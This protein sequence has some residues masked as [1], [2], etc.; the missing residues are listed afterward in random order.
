MS[1]FNEGD[2]IEGKYKVIK[3]IGEGGM[4]RV[5]L[6]ED[7]QKA[8]KWALKVNRDPEEVDAT[9][10]EAY[11]QFLKEVSALST[12]KHP[13]I[14]SI[15]D[16]FSNGTQH[17]VVEEFIEGTSLEDYIKYKLPGDQEVISWAIAICDI[18][19][20]LHRN[21]IIF[22]DIKPANIMLLKNGGIKLID[23]AITRH[24]KDGKAAD[25]M[26][27]GTPGYA[28]P[29][30]Y[31]KSQ[32]DAR[33]DIYSLGAT[34]HQLLTGIDPQENP[35][36]FEEVDHIR[37]GVDRELARIVRKAVSSRQDDRFQTAGEMKIALLKIQAPGS[38]SPF[39]VIAVSQPP[40][41]PVPQVQIPS[42]SSSK[43]PAPQTIVAGCFFEE[44]I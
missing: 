14:P 1:I 7:L 13:G 39:P 29:E 38:P 8:F 2:I 25:T 6:V 12:L 3:F 17:Y 21:R 4:N 35:F 15:E 11:N 27:L 42:L 34:M 40:V 19:E 28:A 23:F 5:Y 36:T 41:S 31:G 44:P 43:G 16:Y 32:S 22:R 33:S 30:T 10:Q 9:Q 26:L 37:P 24:Y 20:L 18:L